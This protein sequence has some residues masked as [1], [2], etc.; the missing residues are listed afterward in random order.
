[1]WLFIAF[2]TV[3]LI[4]IAL[5]IQV[6]GFIGLWPT[7]LIVV[8]TAV[9]GTHLVRSQGR[10]AMNDMRNSF[11]EMRDPTEPLAHGA[12]ILIAGV[13]LLTP[14]FFTDAVG[15]LL[16]FP[17]FRAAAYRYLRARVVVQNF[18]MSGMHTYEGDSSVI[19]GEFHAVNEP[20]PPITEPDSYEPGD[21]YL[22][23]KPTH[24][25]SGWTK[26]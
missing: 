10:M 11:S 16:L 1:M 15:F 20:E 17:P 3:P 22:V 25:P 7:L 21:E 8:V 4:E 13:L 9:L 12:M 6:G 2:L 14:G 19:D 23:K 18:S 24:R 5:F 26:H